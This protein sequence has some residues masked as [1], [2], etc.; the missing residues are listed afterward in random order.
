V[1]GVTASERIRD[2][3][4]AGGVFALALPIALLRL[5]VGMAPWAGTQAS[6]SGCRDRQAEERA[7]DRH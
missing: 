6:S 1:L 2:I 7:I 5:R 4:G 3:A